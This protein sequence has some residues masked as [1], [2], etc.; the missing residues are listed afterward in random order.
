[1]KNPITHCK[2]R[3]KLMQNKQNTFH[4]QTWISHSDN[5]SMK[6]NIWNSSLASFKKKRDAGFIRRCL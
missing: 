5:T 1:M 6:D 3:Q 4:S 2:D